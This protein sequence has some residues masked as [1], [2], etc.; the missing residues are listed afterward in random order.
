MK[1]LRIYADTSVFGGCF[2]EEFAEDSKALFNEIMAGKFLLVISATNVREL[3]RA[4][5]Q[6][7]EVLVSLPPQCVEMIEDSDEIDQLRDA[8]ISADVVGPASIS[9]AE[10]I[11]AASVAEVDM[12]VSWNF[13]HIVHYDKISGYQAVNLLKGYKPLRI[14][15]PKEVIGS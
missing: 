7:R 15:S 12:V 13:R 8:Y 1:Q 10:H 2:D 9:D 11:A 3:T 6:V 5:E 14:H 4:P